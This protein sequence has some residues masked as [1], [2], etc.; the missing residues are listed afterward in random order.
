[1]RRLTATKARRATPMLDAEQHARWIA[2]GCYACPMI[3]ECSAR[4]G[5]QECHDMVL[6]RLNWALALTFCKITLKIDEVP[7]METEI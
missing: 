7:K 2:F 1:M 3:A 6:G 4:H 5:S